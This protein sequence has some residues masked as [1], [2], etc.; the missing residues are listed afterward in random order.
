[1][2]FEKYI[3]H[4]IRNSKKGF[5]YRAQK[6]LSI[7]SWMESYLHFFCIFFSFFNIST[8]IEEFLFHALFI[9]GEKKFAQ[10]AWMFKYH[11]YKLSV[12]KLVSFFSFFLLQKE[13]IAITN[14]LQFFHLTVFVFVQ[15][16][17]RYIII[18]A[19]LCAWSWEQFTIFR[20]WSQYSTVTNL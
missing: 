1:M 9:F 18:N 16:E 6:K 4:E 13:K 11:F 17:K 3:M 2:K 8:V 7:V 12:F 14:A 10:F 19:I 20:S 5:F 15:K